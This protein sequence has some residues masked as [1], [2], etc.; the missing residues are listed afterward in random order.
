[1]FGV[2]AVNQFSLV[3]LLGDNALITISGIRSFNAVMQATNEGRNTPFSARVNDLFDDIEQVNT[4]AVVFDNYA[5]F[6]INTKF[7]PAVLVFDELGQ[8]FSSI[9]QYLNVDTIVQ[10][11]I[12]RTTLNQKLL[13]RTI[14]NKL[15]EAFASSER[16]RC[17]AYLGEFCSN[18]PEKEQQPLRL[19]LVY[20][21]VKENGTVSATPYI[22]RQ[23]VQKYQKFLRQSTAEVDPSQL[24]PF[25]PSTSDNARVL[26]IDVQRARNAWKIG[27][28]IEWDFDAKLS[29]YQ[30]IAADVSANNSLEQAAQELAV[31]QKGIPTFESF[32]PLTA[33]PNQIVR[34]YGTNLDSVLGVLVNRRTINHN[35]VSPNELTIVIPDD[36][37]TSSGY[38]ELITETFTLTSE[39]F[40]TPTELTIKTTIEP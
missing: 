26:T 14:D 28:F 21:D 4:A 3:N 8:S 18:E 33:R 36:G 10:F 9:D 20:V 7:G 5:M 29:H 24:L 16:E 39:D 11:S 6:S 32:S 25:G 17:Q 13:F 31:Y 12:A 22:D 37:G 2:G 27:L 1:L 38:V 40:D 30:C 34:I 23:S 35:I 19:K 15:Y